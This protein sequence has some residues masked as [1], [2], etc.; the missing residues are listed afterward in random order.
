MNQRK[1]PESKLHPERF[2]K[3]TLYFHEPELYGFYTF[4]VRKLKVPSF[5]KSVLISGGQLER[6]TNDY[7]CYKFEGEGCVVTVHNLAL[8]YMY[9][10]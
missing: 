2:K 4:L 7:L 10:H 3:V 8:P 9:K 5:K 6:E 1:I